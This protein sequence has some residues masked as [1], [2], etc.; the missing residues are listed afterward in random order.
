M[1]GATSANEDRRSKEMEWKV[2]WWTNK[3]SI[4]KL[5]GNHP[6]IEK[7]KFEVWFAMG[8]GA[9]GGKVVTLPPCKV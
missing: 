4:G 5:S 8:Y 7:R 3:E 6:R 9:K 2:R 1:R